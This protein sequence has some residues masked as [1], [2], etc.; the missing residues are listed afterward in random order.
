MRSSLKYHCAN[1]RT[2]SAFSLIELMVAVAVLSMLMALLGQMFGIMSGS[3]RSGQRRVN[4][5]TKARAMLDLFSRDLQAGVFRTDLAAFP[6]SRMAF[7]TERAGIGTQGATLR[8]VSLVEYSLDTSS[9]NSTLQRGDMAIAWTSPASDISFANTTSLP[10]ASTLSVRDTAPGVV[11]FQIV[12]ILQ[13]GT[14]TTSYISSTTNPVRTVGITLAVID[15]QTMQRLTSTQL[16]ALRTGLTNSITSGSTVKADWEKYL[17]SGLNWNSY[18]R[19]L[20][21][22]LRIFERYIVLPSQP[23]L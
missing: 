1:A 4:N 14:F 9:T 13:D 18:P 7:Y 19:D 20:A 21:T 6:G 10:S 12:F 16:A 5:F 3:Y 17:A 8:N 2:P 11:G 22:G 15:D 23:T